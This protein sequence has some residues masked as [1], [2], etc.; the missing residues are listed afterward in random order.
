MADEQSTDPFDQVIQKNLAQPKASAGQDQDPF[1][2]AMS[3]KSAGAKVSTIAAPADEYDKKLVELVVRECMTLIKAD[4]QDGDTIN[5]VANLAI[6][7]LEKHF[8]VE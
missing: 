4:P 6:M 8:G 2:L 1:D 5:C 3:G 7:K